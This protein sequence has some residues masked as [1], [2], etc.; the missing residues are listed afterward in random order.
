VS[1]V[2]VH[3]YYTLLLLSD[4]NYNRITNLLA[5]GVEALEFV[6]EIHKAETKE[7]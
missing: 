4:A 7:T 3:S 2:L 6:T 5:R 1:F